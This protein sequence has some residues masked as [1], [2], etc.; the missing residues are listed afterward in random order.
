MGIRKSDSCSHHARL[1]LPSRTITA[2]KRVWKDRKN[3]RIPT[4]VVGI[5]PNSPRM[6]R[7]AGVKSW[8][9]SVDN[10]FLLGASAL[11]PLLCAAAPSS[12]V[13]TARF[14]GSRW[15]STLAPS[16]L[17]RRKPAG[18]RAFPKLLLTMSHRFFLSPSIQVLERNLDRTSLGE[19]YDSV[20]RASSSSWSEQRLS[21]AEAARRG[22]PRGRSAIVSDRAVKLPCC[23]SSD[24]DDSDSTNAAEPQAVDSHANAGVEAENHESAPSSSDVLSVST[25]FSFSLSSGTSPTKLTRGRTARDE[26]TLT[27]WEEQRYTSGCSVHSP[28]PCASGNKG[29]LRSRCPR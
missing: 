10:R 14:V 9:V 13:G 20:C 21:A 4:L 17:H 5:F 3:P 11:N 18:G 22:A 15:T 8:I 25:V 24:A 29:P 2:K 7:A 26:P 27:V 6:A 1:K 28:T 12:T 16:V 23:S 19:G